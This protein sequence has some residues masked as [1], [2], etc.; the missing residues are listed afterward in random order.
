MSEQP[1][2]SRR[3]DPKTAGFA[4]PRRDPAGP[5]APFVSGSLRAGSSDEDTRTQSR[6]TPG[7][8]AGGQRGPW[9]LMILGSM[10]TW[11]SV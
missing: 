9:I 11:L 7:I 5:H 4:P 6:A 8:Q 10:W 3:G 2:K 1:G